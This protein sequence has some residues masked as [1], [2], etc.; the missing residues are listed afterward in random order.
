MHIDKQLTLP[1]ML[2]SQARNELSHMSKEG[3]SM[4]RDIVQGDPDSIYYQDGHVTK[5]E[6]LKLKAVL[7]TFHTVMQTVEPSFQLVLDELYALVSS[8]GEYVGLMAD[9]CAS[10]LEAF[11]ELMCCEPMDRLMTVYHDM[12]RF[13]RC[14]AGQVALGARLVFVVC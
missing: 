6:Y 9:D 13:V 4:V 1:V 3:A 11:M 5:P 7:Q 8:S 10:E 2:P 14:A 12:S